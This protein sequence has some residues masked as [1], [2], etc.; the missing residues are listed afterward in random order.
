MLRHAPQPQGGIRLRQGEI[1]QPQHGGNQT[2]VA[3][4]P[5]EQAR[6][7]QKIVAVL[8]VQPFD[9]VLRRAL[10]QHRRLAAVQHAEI[11]FHTA[12]VEVLPHEAHA[13]GVHGAHPHAVQPGLQQREF[14]AALRL[15]R[16]LLPQALIDA[17]AHLPRRRV[18]E[19]HHQQL[20]RRAGVIGIGQF[21]HDTL[22]KNARLARA[23]GCRHQY[24]ACFGVDRVQLFLRPRSFSHCPAPPRSAAPLRQRGTA[25]ATCGRDLR[26]PAGRRRGNRSIRRYVCNRRR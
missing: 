21:T 16:H 14:P 12:G 13:E 3:S 20:V 8:A 7:R 10:L 25:P 11:R 19:G 15:F 2:V 9:H 18:G 17:L 5:L 4:A 22:H 6:Q 24:R 23:G 1:R 26:P